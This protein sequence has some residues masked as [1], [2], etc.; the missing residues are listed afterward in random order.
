MATQHGCL[1]EFQPEND[2]IT[3]YME[4]AALYFEANSIGEK[5]KQVAILLSSIGPAMYALLSDLCGPA[6][7]N[8]KSFEEIQAELEKHYVPKRIII[9]ERFHFHKREQGM[10]E[11]I[12]DFDAA[13]RKLAIHC[14]FGTVLEDRQ[15]RLWITP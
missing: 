4:R 2:H 10:G 8:A 1:Q 14:N 12:S 6:K 13:L 5:K 15:F 3:A 9:A 11:L 7:P